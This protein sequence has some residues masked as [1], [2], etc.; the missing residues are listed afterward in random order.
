MNVLMRWLNRLTFRNERQVDRQDRLPLIAHYWDGGPPLGHT[1]RDISRRGMYLLTE[2]RWY[3]GTLVMVSLQREDVSEEDPDRCLIVKAK[4]V[5]TGDD[6]VG[7]TFV[8]PDD[9]ERISR[10]NL[11]DGADKK[12]ID[13][14]LRQLSSERGQA[15]IEYILVL[16]LIFLLIINLIN[17]GAF[18]FA[19][20]GVA[21]AARAG[22]DYAALGGASAGSL[23]SATGAQVLFLVNQDI[24]SLRNNPSAVVNVCKKNGATVTALS[25]SCAYM[26]TDAN[27]VDPE[28]ASYVITSVDVTY[29]YVPFIPASFRFPSLRVYLTIPPTTIHRRA[30]VRSMQ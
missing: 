11:Q 26:S 23:G 22:A 2:Q 28:S 25:G 7:F 8:T 4:V 17:F 19:W 6:G 14:F 5:R 3:P 27:A 16:P 29:T 12:T 24:A 20:I 21:N 10:E 9:P 18:F 1:V 13:R 30:F 15:L